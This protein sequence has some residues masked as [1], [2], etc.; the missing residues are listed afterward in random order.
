MASGG[1]VGFEAVAWFNGGLF[2]D[3]AALPLEK[4]DIETVLAAADLDWSE[5]LKPLDTIECR[6]A[7]LTPDDREPEWPVADVVIGN[8]P[9]LGGKLL[10]THLGEDYVAR[11]FK[12]YAGRVPAEAD[13]VCSGSRK[14]GR[15]I[16]SGKG[17]ASGARR[18][19]LDPG[20]REPAGAR[21]RRPR[22]GGS[23]RRGA[24]SRG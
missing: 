19:E 16:A 11:M 7:V 12:T 23:S 24:T 5:I 6:D 3:G 9:F 17:L 22:R 13:L 8:P 21:G 1:R 10:I 2:D 4:S 14:A 18:D 20:R 15:Q